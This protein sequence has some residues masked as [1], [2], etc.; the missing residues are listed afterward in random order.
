VTVADE[1]GA[2]LEGT[3]GRFGAYDRNLVSNE[4]VEV[5]A[6][7][8]MPAE[9]AAKTF[10]LVHYAGLVAEGSIDPVMSVPY[11][12]ADLCL[13]SGVLRYLSPGFSLT[14]EDLAWLMIVISDNVATHLVLSA[15]GGLEAVNKR[16]S[17]LGL[18]SA[19]VNPRFS[20]TD[21]M[22]EEPFATST[23]RDLAEVYCH[24]DERCREKLF[25]Q[26][27]TDFLPRRLPHASG[28]ADFGIT[29][30]VRV[31]NK[32]G[33][34]FLTCTD[35]GLFETDD[36]SW[37]VGAMA[38]EQQDLGYRGRRLRPDGLRPHRGTAVPPLGRVHRLI[39]RV[40]P[41]RLIR[42]PS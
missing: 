33:G 5:N 13:G 24:L 20:H 21:M 22:T 41:G 19:W 8:P 37:V 10:I 28:P 32:T 7:E 36:A 18:T 23:P 15:V 25:R 26:Q 9:S 11:T 16:M 31:F 3:P 42:A 38:A 30:P 27:S 34:G 39:P 14:L 1:I 40:V 6:G 35:S 2:M 17:S 29:M 12:S 4:T